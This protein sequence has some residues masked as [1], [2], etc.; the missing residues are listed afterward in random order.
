MYYMDLTKHFTLLRDISPTVDDYLTRELFEADYYDEEEGELAYNYTAKDVLG[1]C[2]SLVINELRDI[3]IHFAIDV[4]TLTRD[5][6]TCGYVYLIR[7]FVD[8]PYLA[9]LLQATDTVNAVAKYVDTDERKP[10]L[11]EDIV[12]IVNITSHDYE[13]TE[14]AYILPQTYTDELFTTYIKKVIST[15]NTPDAIITKD[16]TSVENY[17]KHIATL[18]QLAYR[19]TYAVIGMLNLEPQ[20]DM[21]KISKLLRDYDR[22]KLQPDNIALYAT[23]DREDV[24]TNLY[25]T[26][27]KYMDY[28][29]EN[30]PH[31]VEY[32]LA[33]NPLKQRFTLD[34]LILLVVHH[35]EPGTTPDEFEHAVEDTIYKLRDILSDQYRELA[36]RMVTTLQPL[37]AKDPVVQENE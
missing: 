35:I 1:A 4:D 10:N 31:H 16:L 2:Y 13:L 30:S 9:K 21:S 17:T 33:D 37:M 3:G 36:K 32:W 11:L 28:H 6:Y 20:L 27:K 22:D 25:A 7:K 5:I 8:K 26:K 34:N 23:I 24:P 29:H 15:I 19:Y 12:N 14:M 18:R